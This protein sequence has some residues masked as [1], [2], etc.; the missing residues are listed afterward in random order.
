[1]ATTIMAAIFL[2]T[3]DALI[4]IHALEILSLRL[5]SGSVPF[6]LG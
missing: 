2:D 1:M 6:P 4:E 5:F 3:T